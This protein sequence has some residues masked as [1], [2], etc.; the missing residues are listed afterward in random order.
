MLSHVFVDTLKSLLLGWGAASL[1]KF[2]TLKA[3]GPE[4]NPQNPYRKRPERKYALEISA[5]GRQK[6][7]DLWN[8]LHNQPNLSGK[9]HPNLV[10]LES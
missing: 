1:G 5:L 9:F 2:L 4:F 3:Q 8:T 10:Y 6:Q 7:E